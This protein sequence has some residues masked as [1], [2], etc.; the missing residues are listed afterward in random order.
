I[1]DDWSQQGPFSFNLCYLSQSTVG[2]EDNYASDQVLLFPNPGSSQQPIY[3][4]IDGLTS[5]WRQVNIFDMHGRIITGINQTITTQN[6]SR[7]TIGPGDL[8]PGIYFIQLKTDLGTVTR[9]LVILD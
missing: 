8:K 6:K 3:I 7:F 1:Y 5:S 2:L 9:K 4:E